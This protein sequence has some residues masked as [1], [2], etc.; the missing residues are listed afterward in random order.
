MEPTA[1]TISLPTKSLT[2]DNIAS[3]DE[4]VIRMTRAKKLNGV[5]AIENKMLQALFQLFH[6]PIVL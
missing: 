6:I 2:S 3:T 1:K 5:R 4:V